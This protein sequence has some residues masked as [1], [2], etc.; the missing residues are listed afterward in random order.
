MRELTNPFRNAKIVR[1][2]CP[3]DVYLGSTG[4]ERG[5]VGHILSRSELMD[6]MACPRR[7]LFGF[8][9]DATDATE[10]GDLADCVVLQPTEFHNRFAVRPSTYKDAKTGEDKKWT[11]A[12]NACKEW[13]AKNAASKTVISQE[14]NAKAHLLLQRLLEH[15]ATAELLRESQ[16][17]VMVLGEYWDEDT[18]LIVPVRALIDIVPYVENPTFKK[19]LCD[20]K[21]AKSAHPRRWPRVVWDRQ[22]HIQGAFHMALYTA[23]TGEE[24]NTWLHLIAENMPPFEPGRRLLSEEFLELGRF[25]FIQALR[26]Y[27]QCLKANDF[28]GYERGTILPS[29]PGW[30][31]TE[32]EPF[33]LTF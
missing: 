7:W 3:S 32:P 12:A 21:T 28:P 14:D 16:K 1:V 17:Q 13:V 30:G 9:E 25:A 31:I 24:R 4:D 8:Q 15:S 10:F 18:G 26:D 6:F 33:M 22:Y 19:C 29:L 11:M 27:C 5:K 23:A 20:F 2:N